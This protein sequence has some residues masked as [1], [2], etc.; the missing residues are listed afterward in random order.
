MEKNIYNVYVVVKE[1]AKSLE[2]RYE[3]AMHAHT[4]A[5]WLL[6]RLTDQSKLDLMTQ[7]IIEM[8]PK[9]V[10]QLNAWISQHLD[11]DYPLHYVLGSVPFGPLTISV[12]APTLIP[13]P[14]TEEWMAALL[15]GF[16]PIKHESLKILDMG[17][18]SGC[19]ALW[20]AKELPNSTIYAVDVSDSALALA[21][22]NAEQNN[23]SNI[24]FIKSN[25]FDLVPQDIKF[26]CIFSNPPYIAPEDWNDL[27]P[28]I[29]K[30]EDRGALIA[31]NKGLEI[32]T[33][34]VAHAPYYLNQQSVLLKHDLASLIVE[35]G[36]NQGDDVKQLF[37]T[38][39]F[40]KT[41]VINDFSGHNRLVI[42]SY[43]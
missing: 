5:W 30:W 10:A 40:A 6:E 18:G 39:G 21:Q 24:V 31:G 42:G 17:T 25:L 2:P 11:E 32:I 22:K 38:A 12:K 34:L 4:A 8:S 37:T 15:P 33:Q 36:Y 7:T 41:R 16:A 23:I 1:V 29:R 13:R 20:L 19:I 3:S 26:D 9:D 28:A 14:E 35:I 27:S 43:T